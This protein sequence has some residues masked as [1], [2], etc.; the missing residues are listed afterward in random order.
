MFYNKSAR[1]FGG[2][3]SRIFLFDAAFAKKSTILIKN[4]LS[5]THQKAV[6]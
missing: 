3:K 5:I 6:L 4:F 2:L 1:I